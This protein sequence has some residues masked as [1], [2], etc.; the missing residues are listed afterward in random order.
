MVLPGQRQLFAGLARSGRQPNASLVYDIISVSISHGAPIYN[1][2]SPVGCAQI[3]L[4]AA[5]GLLRLLGAEP[6]PDEGRTEPLARESLTPLVA[7][8]VRRLESDADGLAWSLRHAFD[9]LVEAAAH[10]RTWE[11]D[12]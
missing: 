5:A 2:G 1:S 8:G 6:G 10:E 4:G 3:Y 12:S 7:A 11:H 9:R